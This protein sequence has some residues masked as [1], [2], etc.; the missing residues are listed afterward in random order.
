MGLEGWWGIA[1]VR[2]FP[3]CGVGG[4]GSVHAQL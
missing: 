4:I 2:Q 1:L 3:H